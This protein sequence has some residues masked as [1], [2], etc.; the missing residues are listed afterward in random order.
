MTTIEQ[1]LNHTKQ[2][3]NQTQ[4]IVGYIKSSNVKGFDGDGYPFKKALAQ[5]RAV[6]SGA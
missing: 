6:S 4:M 2:L 3:L 1:H 5:C